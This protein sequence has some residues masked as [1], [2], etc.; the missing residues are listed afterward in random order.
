MGAMVAMV[1][2]L[3]LVEEVVRKCPWRVREYKSA[4]CHAWACIRERGGVTDVRH[5]LKVGKSSCAPKHG[6][7]T[8]SEIPQGQT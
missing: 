2:M 7:R 1:A 5:G 8:K 4:R 6:R 3:L